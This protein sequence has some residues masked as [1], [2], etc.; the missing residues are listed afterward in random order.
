MAKS[1]ENLYTEEEVSLA[2]D[3]VIGDDGIRSKE[4]IS[5]LRTFL[6]EREEL[7]WGL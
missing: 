2:V 3:Y 6:K 5:L 4:V 7:Q 1:K